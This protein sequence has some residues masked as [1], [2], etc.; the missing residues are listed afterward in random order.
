MPSCSGPATIP[1]SMMGMS[2]FTVTFIL[3]Q[4]RLLGLELDTLVFFALNDAQ[5][6]GAYRRHADLYGVAVERKVLQLVL[7]HS[8]A[9]TLQIAQVADIFIDSL[10]GVGYLL[11]ATF[12]F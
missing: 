8:V 3:R 12:K 1:F 11:N 9:D 6:D 10:Y 2:A 5:L 7:R 4:R